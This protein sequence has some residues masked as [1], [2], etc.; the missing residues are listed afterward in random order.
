MKAAGDDKK[1]VIEH[2]ENKKK[3][4]NEKTINSDV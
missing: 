4:F 3:S 2:F 1:H